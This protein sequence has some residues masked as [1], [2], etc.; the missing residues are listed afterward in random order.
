[1]NA[2]PVLIDFKLELERDFLTEDGSPMW[3]LSG[4]DALYFHCFSLKQGIGLED[5][6]HLHFV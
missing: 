2:G 1:M 6:P 5:L 4:Q 3:C